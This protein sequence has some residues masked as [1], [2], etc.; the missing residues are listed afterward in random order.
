ML[1]LTSLRSNQG[2]GFA[3]RPIST[4]RR[5]FPEAAGARKLKTEAIGPWSRQL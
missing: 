1:S 2:F 3:F 4:S 5:M